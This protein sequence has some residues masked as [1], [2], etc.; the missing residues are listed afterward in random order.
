[1]ILSDQT[2]RLNKIVTP[3]EERGKFR[4]MS[5]GLS[6]C[7]YDCRVDLSP[8]MIVRM[9]TR[10]Q[11]RLVSTTDGDGIILSPGKSELVAL[12][13]HFNMPTGVCGYTRDKST[14]ARRGLMIAQAVL[15]P[16]WKGWMALRVY[17]VSDDDLVLV[18]GDPITQ[19]VFHWLD[20]V[21]ENTYTGKYQG[22][23]RG[24]QGPRYEE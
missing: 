24:P 6:S 22:Q 10:S 12:R 23:E 13:E 16:G 3:C 4:G 8:D 7:G 17:N 5:F 21:P 9:S 2:I 20:T 11:L 18:N 1:M 19:V 14:W 15:E